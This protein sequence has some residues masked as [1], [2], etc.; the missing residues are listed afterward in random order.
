M[1]RLGPW[2]G[3]RSVAVAVS[4]GADS[5]ALALLARSWGNPV[6]FIVDH[7]LRASSAA[8]AEWTRT[9]LVARGIASR[10]LRLEG[11]QAG[12]ALAARAR[13]ARYAALSA[14]CRAAG[15]V[16]LLLGHH[17]G[18][19][20][21]TVLMRQRAGSGPD[22]CAGMA[23]LAESDDIRLLRPLLA[24]DPA[25]LRALVAKAGITPVEDPSNADLRTT[26][27]RLRQEIG[28]DRSELLA[29]AARA[30]H[31]RAL[32]EAAVAEELAA[33]AAIHP[34]GFAVLAPGPIRS[35][36]L[37]A[38]LR[39]LSGRRFPVRNVAALAA[40]P[41][42]G[43]DRWRAAPAG[44]AAWTWMAA[45]PR[46]AHESPRQ[47]TGENLLPVHAA[48]FALPA[49]ARTDDEIL[50]PVRDGGDDLPHQRGHVAAVAVEEQQHVALRRRDA[51]RA[52]A[53]V[54][55]H[56]LADDA[57]P[58]RPR[59]FGGAVV[60]AV[61][62][63]QHFPGQARGET[64][65]YHVGDGFLLVEAGDDDGNVGGHGLR[66]PARRR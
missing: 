37:A 38:L 35:Q 59:P 4:G 54:P 56:G 55:A 58:R 66:M 40:Q 31:A 62:H 22:G 61:V 33:R 63:D 44:R 25:R 64:F 28:G 43:D 21:E 65:L 1:G 13:A 34:E 46:G 8:E 26:R 45:D 30:G 50:R 15:L 5:L 24:F 39:A 3:C 47:I 6:A 27:A 51:R 23:A 49:R 7:G 52:R 18:D 17:A 16:D 19:Q 20:A 48:R 2:D 29:V 9:T 57:R 60:A 12:S 32:S 11:L 10:V 42:A 36:S 41:P 53:P 14:A